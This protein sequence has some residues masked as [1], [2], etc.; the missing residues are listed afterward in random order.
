MCPCRPAGLSLALLASL[1][2]PSDRLPGHSPNTGHLSLARSFGNGKGDNGTL[3]LAP[4]ALQGNQVVTEFATDVTCSK[5]DHG[6]RN[7]RFLLNLAP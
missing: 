1:R 5:F 6:I 4:G 7:R 2:Y 3:R